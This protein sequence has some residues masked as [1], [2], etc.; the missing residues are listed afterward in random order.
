MRFWSPSRPHEPLE[1]FRI[2][3]LGNQKFA[4]RVAVLLLRSGDERRCASSRQVNEMRRA[5]QA[6]SRAVAAGVGIAA[7]TYAVIASMA[8]WRYGRISPS[9]VLGR[10]ELLDR[11]MPFYEVVERH[12][13]YVRAPAAV[14]LSAAKEQDLFAIPLVRTIFRARAIALRAAPDDQQRPRGLL[15]EVQ[16][17]GWRVLAEEADREV[18]VGAVTQPWQANVRFRS[19]PPG[20][21]EAFAEPGYVKIVWTLRVHPLDARSSIFMTETRAMA[22]DL[23]A[24]ARFRRYWAFASPGIALIRRLSLGPLKRDAERRARLAIETAGN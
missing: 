9:T 12:Y 22:T 19:V 20:E 1:S 21:F 7:G 11:F 10:D 3:K 15:K 2:P 8:W 4:R 17:L 14:S 24:R 16:A 5:I 13:V 6:F 23:A 18:V